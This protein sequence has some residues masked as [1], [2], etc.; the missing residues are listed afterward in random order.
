MLRIHVSNRRERQQFDHPAGPVEFG[1]GPKVNAYPRCVIQDPSVSRNQM[2][3]EELP[4]ARLRVENLSDNRP[5]VL[6]DTTV[7]APRAAR[8]VPL[9]LRLTIGETLVEIDAAADDVGRDRLETLAPPVRPGDGADSTVSLDALGEAPSAE[10]LAGWFET[11]LAVQ[12]AAAGSPEF[13]E[14]TARALVN[15]VGLDRGLVLLR[16]GERWDVAARAVGREGGPGRDF[17]AGILRH[18]VAERRTFYQAKADGGLPDAESLAGVE[19][20][21]ASP[22][23]DA[24][25]NVVG[26]L[27]GSR[28]RGAGR[29]AAGIGKLEAQVVQVLASAVGAGLARRE[30]EADAARLRVQLEQFVTP[31]LARELERD[32]KLLDGRQREVTVLFSDIRGFS[33]LTERLA[34]TAPAEVC[35]L[36][37]EVMDCL[38]EHVRATE[39]VVVDYSGDGLCAMWNAPF[40]QP[41]HAARACRAARALRAD[42]P[43]LSARWQERLGEPLAVGLGI[44]SGVA[45]VGNTG[46]RSKMQYGPLGHTVN[47]ASRVEGATKHLGVPVLLTGATRALLRDEFAV[48][49]LCRARLAGLGEPVELYELHGAK[50]EP[51]WAHDRD[52]YEEALRL[53]EAGQWAAACAAVYPLLAGRRGRYDVPALNLLSRAVECLKP[54]AAKSDPVWEFTTK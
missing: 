7:L 36:V 19:A 32:P 20:V 54:A 22:V 13:Y 26:A 12:R 28:G 39:G 11:V 40:D 9:P 1:R 15:L 30:R 46:S 53:Y 50:A 44:N 4:A 21:V 31:A 35:R 34:P 14:Q 49:R 48:R 10:R 52:A 27:Y 43:Q 24:G 51:E 41:D 42:L 2:R 23:F 17:S 47:L 45:M 3:V 37:A 8:E 18:V 29:T 6:A 38:T 33:R 5:I 16:R 25:E